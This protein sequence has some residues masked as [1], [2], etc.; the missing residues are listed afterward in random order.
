[1]PRIDNE[2][3]YTSAIEKY[4][5]T[6]RGVNWASKRNQQLRFLEILKLL[7]DDLSQVSIVDAGCGFGDFY[8]FLEKKKRVPQSY[9]GID[10]VADMCSIA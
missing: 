10:L 9:L 4:G 1:M 8:T 3:F 5:T 2:R 6:A 7:P